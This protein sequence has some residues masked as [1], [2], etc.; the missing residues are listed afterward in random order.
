MKSLATISLVSA[1]L[2]SSAQ[3]SLAGGDDP[4]ALARIKKIYIESVANGQRDQQKES[5]AREL[6]KAGFEIVDVRSQADATLTTLPQM[7]IVVDGDG[8][9]PDKA[10]FTYELAL[11]N[12]TIVWKHR[13]KFVSR[14]TLAE[15]CDYAATKMAAKILK[16]K[17]AS[18]RKNAH[19]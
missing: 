5:L 18:V 6:T 3:L 17:E 14:R 9:V 15:D 10:I 2:F 7:E 11:P 19:K 12:S 13:I 16:D 4:T 8:S 1:I